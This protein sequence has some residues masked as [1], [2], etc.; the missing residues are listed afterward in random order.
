[1]SCDSM[2][3]LDL[4]QLAKDM[5]DLLEPLAEDRGQHLEC[6]VSPVKVVGHRQILAQVLGNLLENATKYAPIGSALKL[7]VRPGAD[8]TGP[9][10]I[11]EDRGP[12]IPAHSREQA[13]KSFVRVEHPLQQPGSG[14]GLAIAAAVA[15]LH[16]GKLILENAEPGLRVRSQLGMAQPGLPQAAT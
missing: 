6:S 4:D 13:V 8:D 11:V 5:I 16:R 10:I 14:L 9:E 1:M 15:R 12:G 3:E 7:L 2:E